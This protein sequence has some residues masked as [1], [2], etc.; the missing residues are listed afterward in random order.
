M[1]R[2]GGSA[3][4]VRLAEQIR[5]ELAVLID[6]EVKDPAVDRVTVSGLELARDLSHA[7]VFVTLAQGAEPKQVLPGLER[8]APF[9]R[10]R[11]GE[12]VKMRLVPTLRFVNDTTLD[13]ANRI[14]ALLQDAA[15]T[16]STPTDERNRN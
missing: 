1:A 9:L 12:R 10:R 3:R 6:S 15:G 8:A 5:R 13:N 4:V 14:E 2:A 16:F 11:L 7:R